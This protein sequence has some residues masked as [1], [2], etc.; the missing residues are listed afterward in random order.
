MCVRKN[1]CLNYKTVEVEF[2]FKRKKVFRKN[3]FLFKRRT[4]FFPWKKVKSE[5]TIFRTLI[6]ELLCPKCLT[7]TE[8]SVE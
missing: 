5:L 4:R 1:V 3:A 8:S 6:F 2:D 7:E